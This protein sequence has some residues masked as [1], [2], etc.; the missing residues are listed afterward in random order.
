MN[1][2]SLIDGLKRGD[3]KAY[4]Q[5]YDTNYDLLCMLAYQY[6]QD[7][8]I[9]ESLV[10]DVIHHL[11][12]NR[13]IL[14]VHTSL[15][16]YLVKAVKN[17]C[18]NHLEHLQVKRQAE[19][20]LAQQMKERQQDYISDFDYPLAK[21]IALELEGSIAEVIDSLSAECREVFRMSRMDGLSYPEISERLGISI[22]TV[23]YHIKNAL[24]QLR[25]QLKDYL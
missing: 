15:N 18:I 19:Q 22:N 10:G 20:E 9:A 4:R 5:L 8:F 17:R 25:E 7:S 14:Q 11:W 6:V 24:A 23:K 2:N 1:S 16:A 13:E 21:L 12:E 3:E